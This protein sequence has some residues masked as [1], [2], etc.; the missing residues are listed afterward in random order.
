MADTKRV[1]PADVYD[2]LEFSALAFGGIGAGSYWGECRG[3]E[4]DKPMCAIGHRWAIAPGEGEDSVTWAAFVSA[5][6]EEYVNDAAVRAINARL[7]KPQDSRVTFE[8]WCKELNVIRGSLSLYENRE[9]R[10]Q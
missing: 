5:D 2:A 3:E 4:I 8:Q 7:G 10:K 6:I 9:P 1:L